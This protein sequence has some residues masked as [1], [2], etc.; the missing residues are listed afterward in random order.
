MLAL[1]TCYCNDVYR[2]AAK[3]GIEV[4]H[5]DVEC[6]AEFPA[7][8]E[9]AKEIT[10]SARITAHTSGDRI[11]ELAA[12]VDRRAEIRNSVRSAIPIV[13]S[14]VEVDPI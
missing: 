14:H 2:E 8:G 1:A 4:S 10:Y 13:L 3:M 5:V 6:S 12:E 7:E 11:Q 9:P